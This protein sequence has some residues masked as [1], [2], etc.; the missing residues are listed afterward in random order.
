[1]KK[2]IPILILITIIF[3][4]CEK[5]DF[6]VKNPITPNLVLRFYD[7]TNQETLKTAKLLSVW[8]EGKDTIDDY[9]SIT[10]DSI[11]I[12]LNSLTT[13]TIYHL[14]INEE[15]GAKADNLYTTFTINYTPEDVYVS[16]SCGYK[17]IFN[18]V[19]FSSDNTNWIKEFTPETL[20]IIED[21]NSAHVQIFH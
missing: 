18:D 2:I 4:T 3:S 15:D 13:E 16:R 6:C 5:D 20:T 21:Q 12:P 11:A 14:K 1:M 7:E 19:T 17:V 10:T 9:T 8:A